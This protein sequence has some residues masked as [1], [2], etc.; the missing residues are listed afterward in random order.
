[1]KHKLNNYPKF[2]VEIEVSLD[3]LILIYKL[4]S[5]KL[6]YILSKQFY[7]KSTVIASF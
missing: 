2:Y 7:N 3:I 6:K 4:S 1:M 5:Q